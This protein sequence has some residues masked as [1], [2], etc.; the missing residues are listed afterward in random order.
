M[1][2]GDVGMKEVQF[3]LI[4]EDDTRKGLQKRIDEFKRQLSAFNDG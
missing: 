2:N 3:Y 4:F 1:V